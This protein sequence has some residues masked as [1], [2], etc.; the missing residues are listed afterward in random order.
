MAGPCFFILS[1]AADRREVVVAAT[2]E[3]GHAPWKA[4]TV[5]LIK[6]MLFGPIE[7]K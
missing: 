5:L 1:A 6:L 3:D 7:I 2:G 4:R